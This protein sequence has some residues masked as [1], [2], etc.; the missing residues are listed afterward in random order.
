MGLFSSKEVIEKPIK[1][2][3]YL[4]VGHGNA[5]SAIF[6]TLNGK[7]H[8]LYTISGEHKIPGEVSAQGVNERALTSLREVLDETAKTLKS[9]SNKDFRYA[10][11]EVYCILAAPYY[12]SHT[13]IVTKKWERPFTITEN[14]LKTILE[15]GTESMPLAHKDAVLGNGT[16]IIHERVIDISING[17]NTENPVGKSAENLQVSI[18]RTEIDIELYNGIVKT[19]GAH[20]AAPLYIEPFSLAAFVT[21]RNRIHQK[22]NFLFVTIGNEVSEISLVKR[23]ILLETVSFPFGKYSLYR[24]VADKIR[25]TPEEAQSRISLYH[26]KKLNP[27]EIQSIS[28]VIE[29]AQAEWF[30][31][32]EKSL[33]AIADESALPP[34]IFIVVDTELKDIFGSIIATEGFASQSLVPSGFTVQTVDTALL[35]DCCTFGLNIRFDTLIAV[36]ASFGSAAREAISRMYP[37]KKRV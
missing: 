21:L 28:E 1:I 36:S 35:A 6:E 30:S 22:D 19:V 9:A 37:Q 31:Y 7:P 2:V 23:S 3:L 27:G 33:V 16:K 24:S 32:L 5:R 8:I 29:G 17:Y 26:D 34:D 14:T 11:E 13:G 20:T 10:A 12:L 15:T 18:F 4:D 25:I